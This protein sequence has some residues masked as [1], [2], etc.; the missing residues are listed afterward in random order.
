MVY[1][2]QNHSREFSTRKNLIIC[3]SVY[4]IMCQ[5]SSRD[6]SN[7]QHIVKIMVYIHI[8]FGRLF[9][10]SIKMVNWSLDNNFREW[11]H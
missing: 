1:A 5:G 3:A 6:Q 4:E 8:M 2:Y 9:D 11:E 7:L 10:N